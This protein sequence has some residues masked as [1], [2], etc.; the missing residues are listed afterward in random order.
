MK[1]I[2]PVTLKIEMLENTHEVKGV[3]E[4]ESVPEFKEALR[5]LADKLASKVT[6]IL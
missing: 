4:Y 6:E 2:I 1:I 5:E 3:L